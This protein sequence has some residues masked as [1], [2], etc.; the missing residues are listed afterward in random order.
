MI[1]PE[2]R[3]VLKAVGGG[4]LV[5]VIIVGL[6]LLLGSLVPSSGPRRIEVIVRF[7]GPIQVQ[8]VPPK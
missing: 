4:A 3:A 1:S 6:G 2:A 7:E 8:I 5:V